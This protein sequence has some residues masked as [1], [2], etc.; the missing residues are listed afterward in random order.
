MNL[1]TK[2][3]F[4][5]DCRKS[6]CNFIEYYYN[7]KNKELFQNQLDYIRNSMLYYVLQVIRVC[8]EL[9]KEN[10]K[11][12]KYLNY[13]KIFHMSREYLKSKKEMTVIFKYI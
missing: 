11:E 8:F 13:L 6:E 5:W 2:K 1:N 4:W 3:N 9:N 10:G 7:I 12:T